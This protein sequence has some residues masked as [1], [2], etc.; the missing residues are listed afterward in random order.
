VPDSTSPVAT[1]SENPDS[2][3]DL[4]ARYRAGGAVLRAS[5]AGLDADTLRARPIEGKMSSLEVVCHVADADQFMCDRMKRAIAT[6]I[7][8]LMGVNAITYLELLHYHDRDPEL[9]LR[10]L[11]AQREQMA[12]DLERLPGDA[13]K[14]TAIHSEVGLLTLRQL[15][16]HAVCH[17]ESHAGTIADKHTALGL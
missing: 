8:L 14:R 3:A 10:L 13:W 11:E 5:I 17:L 2:P 7:P 4:L 1:V 15:L 6:E 9:D 16:D 12:A